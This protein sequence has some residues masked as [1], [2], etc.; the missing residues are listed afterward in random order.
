MKFG[1]YHSLIMLR[2]RFTVPLDWLK[3]ATL[4]TYPV[5]LVAQSGMGALLFHNSKTK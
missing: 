3:P 4:V 1:G 2:I 5:F